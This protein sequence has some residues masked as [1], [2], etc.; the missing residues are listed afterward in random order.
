[1]DGTDVGTGVGTVDGTDVGT[2]VGTYVGT[3]VGTDVGTVDGTDVGPDGRAVSTLRLAVVGIRWP[4]RESDSSLS[5]IRW[6]GRES[7]SSLSD[8]K[9]WLSVWLFVA[10][11]PPC[12]MLGSKT[13]A[14]RRVRPERRTL[15]SLV[16]AG[17]AAE[18]PVT[19][20][21]MAVALVST[22]SVASVAVALMTFISL[23]STGIVFSTDSSLLVG[24]GWL[25]T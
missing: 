17:G 25:R 18:P 7:D 19:V 24:L 23:A 11:T 9:S 20:A 15:V 1:V 22:A 2:D 16:S 8:W 6:P 13:V 3:D 5:D 12:S 10:G 4:G 21:S 14:G